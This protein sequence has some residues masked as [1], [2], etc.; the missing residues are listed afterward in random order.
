[1]WLWDEGSDVT[2]S[3]GWYDIFPLSP[4]TYTVVAYAPGYYEATWVQWLS[5]TGGEA[6]S[7]NPW[8]DDT[9]K[10]PLVQLV[11]TA[12]YVYGYYWHDDYWHGEADIDPDSVR[13]LIDGQ[14][15]TAYATYCT[16]EEI[17]LEP[18]DD[19]PDLD[20]P[21]QVTLIVSDLEG[22]TQQVS[23]SSQAI[24]PCQRDPSR[25]CG[26]TVSYYLYRDGDV[27]VDIYN[28]DDQDNWQLYNQ[29]DLGHQSRGSHSVDWDGTDFDLCPVPEGW[30]CIEL[31]YYDHMASPAGEFIGSVWPDPSTYLPLG[32]G[33]LDANGQYQANQL[34]AASGNGKGRKY[35]VWSPTRGK[36]QVKI[37]SDHGLWA[38]LRYE[39]KKVE[40]IADQATLS[41]GSWGLLEVLP[42]HPAQLEARGRYYYVSVYN[43]TGQEAHFSIYA[44]FFQQGQAPQPRQTWNGWYWPSA[45]SPVGPA[46]HMYDVAG[47]ATPLAKYDLVYGTDTATWEL[48]NHGGS[49]DWEGHCR[50]WSLAA[51]LLGCWPPSGGV[52]KDGVPFTQ[53]EIGG[54]YTQLYDG[55]PI[56]A[57]GDANYA[58]PPGYDW[59]GYGSWPPGTYEADQFCKP[60]YDTLYFAL[61]VSTPPRA[62]FMDLTRNPGQVWNFPVFAYASELSHLVGDSSQR[63]HVR[64][65][66]TVTYALDTSYPPDDWSSSTAS[67]GYKLW[68]DVTPPADRSP[69]MVDPDHRP[70]WVDSSLGGG[71]YTPAGMCWPDDMKWSSP[72][73]YDPNDPYEKW[74]HYNPDVLRQRVLLI[75]PPEPGP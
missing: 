62:V 2:D 27:R 13:L 49:Q 45:P 16:D 23:M 9:A 42:T 24:D 3:A 56:D 67:F 25:P 47:S 21:H 10:P 32:E 34:L 33:F 71:K 74:R 7:F 44:Q 1:M 63:Q 72:F 66:T 73:V 60:L 48:N 31:W 15:C 43:P 6:T 35:R 39:D 36:L 20:V 5:V 29:I 51:M 50:G 53:G 11:P 17:L 64:I 61:S 37:L 38:A 68:L 18:S 8:L 40:K 54:L 55:Y 57:H 41:P 4:D 75:W 46:P 69:V 22:D 26:T 59:L 12:D 28:V 70:E 14:D 30:Y 65:D 52:T 19:L 58:K